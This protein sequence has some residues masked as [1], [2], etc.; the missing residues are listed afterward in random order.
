MTALSE[1][2]FRA[3]VIRTKPLS[4]VMLRMVLGGE[5]L[6]DFLSCGRRTSGCGSW[7]RRTRARR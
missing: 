3:E 6:A 1:A 4:A 2:Y 7:C 5:G